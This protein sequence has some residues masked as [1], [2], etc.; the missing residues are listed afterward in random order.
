MFHVMS[1]N[2]IKFKFVRKVAFLRYEP[3]SR[4]CVKNQKKDF[5]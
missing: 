3:I 1:K 2:N 5:S 4:T